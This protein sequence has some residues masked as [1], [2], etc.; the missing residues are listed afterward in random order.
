MKLGKIC[1][2][3]GISL[4]AFAFAPSHITGRAP[5]EGPFQSPTDDSSW[6][7]VDSFPVGPIGPSDALCGL[8][9]YGDTVFLTWNRYN[10]PYVIRILNRITGVKLDSVIGHAVEYK[11]TPVKV[12]D[13][14]YISGFYPSEHIDVYHL[15]TK[16]YL[17][18]IGPFPGRRTR[19]MDW[20]GSKFW[21]GDNYTSPASIYLI[22]RAGN[23]L[24]T[25][26]N[27]GSPSVG[28]IMDLTLD[29]MIPNRL[30]LND[31]SG[32][33]ARY[34][35]FDTIAN[36]YQVLASF[37]PPAGPGSTAEGIGFYGPDGGGYGYVYTNSGFT[38]WVW[39]MKVHE[40]IT[41][42]SKVY[43]AAADYL[44]IMNAWANLIRDSSDGRFPVVSVYDLS[45]NPT[46]PATA[47]YNDGYQVIATWSNFRYNDSTAV[48]DSLAKFIQLGGGVVSIFGADA[49]GYNL[50]GQ[51]Q[52]AYMPFTVRS[53]VNASGS[54]G[55]VH[56]PSHPIMR[57]VTTIVDNGS[58][59]TGNT[60][61]TLRSPNCVPLADYNDGRS[62]VAYFDTSGQRAV[63]IGFLAYW[64]PA[65]QLSGQW[66]RLVV[67]A[68]K[69]VAPS[70]SVKEPIP[71][72]KRVSIFNVSPNPTRGRFNVHWTLP[73]KDGVDLKIYNTLGVNVYSAK[74]DKELLTVEKLPAGIY[75]LRFSANGYEENRKLI[76]LR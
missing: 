50:S 45:S 76:V 63:S 54:M 70:L 18:Q 33:L 35:S 61:A 64:G 37:T 28:W 74:V 36:T 72:T 29:R 3:F 53:Y 4:F 42:Q 34:C 47:W 65:G 57:G 69:W 52:T 46:F 44:D 9:V 12:G 60:P 68:L 32:D 66:V 13:S 58:V 62:L 25:L 5:K 27:T 14:L 1:L 17:R 11:M 56:D 30:W 71:S 6:I 38:L 19:G 43:I 41:S 23:I 16:T 31:N 24:R 75:L 49:I 10:Q 73:N 2:V 21:I 39:K 7:K 26:T 55:T 51:Y 20:D 48:G 67:N 15:P 8:K 22:D 59:S 40:P